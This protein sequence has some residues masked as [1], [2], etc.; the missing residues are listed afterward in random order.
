MPGRVVQR[1]VE[2]LNHRGIALSNADILVL[3][4]AYKPDVSDTRESPAIDII[5]ELEDWN[6]SVAYHDP[7]VSEL[8]ILGERYESV[9][10]TT[11]R[12]EGADCV[13]LVTDHSQFDIGEIVDHSSLLF[14]TRNA[15]AEYASDN[16][17]RL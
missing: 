3:G 4:V 14:D 8:D 12:I 1:V 7:F 17:V 6:A 15:T 5:N 13:V 9:E 11:D 10:L 16:I 2:Q